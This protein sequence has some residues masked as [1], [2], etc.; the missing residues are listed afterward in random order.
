MNKYIPSLNG[1][2]AIS[3]LMVV[4]GHL[5]LR[6]FGG[7]NIPFP[8]FIF[9]NSGLGVN[10]FFVISGFLITKLLME[11]ENASSSINLKNFYGRR[12]LRILPAYYFLLLVYFIL[13]RFSVLHFTTSSWLSSIFYYKYI[14]GGDWESGHFWSLSVEE[15]FYLIWPAIFLL[16]K[17]YRVGF[18]F[19]IILAV[20]FFRLNA[21]FHFLNVPVF[22]SDIS[23]FQRADALMTG[24]LL[25]LFEKSVVQKLHRFS[26]RWTTPFVLLLLIA[27]INSD[28][29]T[30]WNMKYH[31]HL[32]FLLIPL[33][34]GASYSSITN[35]LIAILIIVSI[36]NAGWWFGFLNSSV[37]TVLGKLSYSIYLW[38]QLFFSY[39]AGVF[40]SFPINILCITV[41][42]GLSYFLIEKHFLRIKKK[43]ESAKGINL[44]LV[45]LVP[46]TA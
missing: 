45:P 42:A 2:R 31:L 22:D 18:A 19:L 6:S 20:F 26:R 14:T 32:G 40:H 44:L 39:R 21:Y 12:V 33:A 27:F 38:Q 41:M 24:C 36:K 9:F 29:L 37:M 1:L 23:I 10:I 46:T 34:V 43:Y 5:N 11:E 17:K 8:F 35:V 25:A 30:G 7:I 28:F 16:F 3:I 13:E 15:H 4:F